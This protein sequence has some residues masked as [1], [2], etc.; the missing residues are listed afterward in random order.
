M[1]PVSLGLSLFALALAMVSAP[2]VAQ[3][4]LKQIPM[5]KPVVNE[6]SQRDVERWREESLRWTK[7]P[8]PKPVRRTYGRGGAVR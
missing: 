5:Q 6:R 4:R 8:P 1:R 2:A 7:A 3:I